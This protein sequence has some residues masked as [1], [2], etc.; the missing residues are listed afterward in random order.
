MKSVLFKELPKAEVPAVSYE[1]VLQHIQPLLPVLDRLYAPDIAPY[2]RL[3]DMYLA[4]LEKSFTAN[5]EF[6]RS[7][8]LTLSNDLNDMLERS[9]PWSR[10]DKKDTWWGKRAQ[11]LAVYVDKQK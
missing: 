10:T 8:G 6:V 2:T 9:F 3:S 1:E 4:E 7:T 11:A 5:P